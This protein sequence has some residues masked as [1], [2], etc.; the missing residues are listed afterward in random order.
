M[1]A[2]KMDVRASRDVFPAHPNTSIFDSYAGLRRTTSIFEVGRFGRTGTSDFG[3]AAV[4]TLRYDPDRDRWQF[5]F[6]GGW[7]TIR[8]PDGIPS[9]RQLQWLAAHGLLEIRRRPGRPLSKLDA[10]WA[11][12]REQT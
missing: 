2:P 10:A 9:G 1:S 11:I 12:D 3:G 7:R 6:D 4:V 5:P 8:E